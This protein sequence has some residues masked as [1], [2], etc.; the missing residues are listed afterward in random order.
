MPEIHYVA[1]P[2]AAFGFDEK[3]VDGFS[4]RADRF[5]LSRLFQYWLQNPSQNV[6]L[7]CVP[8]GLLNSSYPNAAYIA[9]SGV[10]DG[11]LTLQSREQVP[12][13]LHGMI[14]RSP[15]PEEPQPGGDRVHARFRV[16]YECLVGYRSSSCREWR[17]NAFLGSSRTRNRS[18]FS[19]L[20][21]GIVA[22]PPQT[23]RDKYLW[24]K[25]YHRARRHMSC[26]AST[27][28]TNR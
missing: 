1:A 28:R 21:A 20:G 23:K 12:G 18:V 16:Q 3:I 10:F 9:P 2:V 14:N 13:L 26:C 15:F 19:N 27:M 11:E 6:G 24:V 5:D 4:P 7:T 25:L 8:R 22:A 17:D